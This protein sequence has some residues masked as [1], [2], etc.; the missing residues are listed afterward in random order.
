MNRRN[1]LI[2]GAV[3]AIIVIA[4]FAGMLPGLSLFDNGTTT[5]HRES[6]GI[7]GTPGHELLDAKGYICSYMNDGLSQKIVVSGSLSC[8]SGSMAYAAV[9]RYRV[10]LKENAWSAYELVSEPGT[11]S[12]YISAA[13]PGEK[14]C[15]IGPAPSY[16]TGPLELAPYTFQIVGDKYASGAIKV[17]LDVYMDSHWINP[18]DSYYWYTMSIDEAYLYEGYGSLTLPTG[19][20]DGVERPYDTFE[21]GQ[22]VKI[23]VETAGGG[24]STS[25][26]N[27][28]VTLNEPYG[29]TIDDPD[30]GGGVVKEQFYQDDTI[31]YFTF[32]VTEEMARKSM[33]SDSPYTV[34]IWNTLIPKG[35]LYI[36]FIDFIAKAPGTVLLNGPRQSKINTVATVDM[37][38]TV[39]TDTQ[40]PID[41]FRVSVIYGTNDVL[42]PSSPTSQNWLLHTT[43][44]AAIY[45]GGTYVASVDFIPTKSSY[46]TLHA[47][48]FDTAGRGS[49]RT[50]TWTLWA[51]TTNPAPDD[52][53]DSQVGY[54]DY[55]GGHTDPWLPWDPGSGNWED[56]TILLSPYLGMVIAI[57]ILIITGILAFF[58]PYFKVKGRRTLIL[59]LG[60]LASVIVYWFYYYGG[61]F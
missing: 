36:D 45:S 7:R 26:Y 1:L 47:K 17:T 10:Y 22:E 31:S 61:F 19:I 51:Y 50:T 21:I 33:L 46:V 43:N 5:I 6:A 24:G 42:L 49:P 53:I 11:T 2:I 20:E 14:N 18:F 30:D 39:N 59:L 29:G 8:D 60:I 57:F 4:A 58:V 32:T 23:R 27:W 52:T 48:A 37:S 40:A 16:P 34:R 54:S 41:Y 44:V 9:Y 13:N 12:K 38:S 15:G 3:A 35:S 25:G 55:S 28:R 56:L